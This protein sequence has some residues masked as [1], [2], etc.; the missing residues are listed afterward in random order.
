MNV[1]LER[2]RAQTKPLH[3]RLEATVSKLGFDASEAG[4]RHYLEKLLGF[5]VPLELDL[6]RVQG[7][8]PLG[9]ELGARL[10]VPALRADLAALGVDARAQ[11]TLA[12]CTSSPP[13]RDVPSALGALYVVESATLG[14]Q[15]LFRE[16][17]ERLPSTMR[18]ASRYLRIYGAAT[19]KRWSDFLQSLA[20]LEGEPARALAEQTA[21]ATFEAIETWLLAHAGE[22]RNTP[23]WSLA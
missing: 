9:L 1:L 21:I 2:L 5:H 19:G 14:G 18:V 10:K 8:D 20:T 16:L 13:V 12:W 4:Y 15:V 11:K 6:S 17:S 7:L 22:D 23:A 3:A